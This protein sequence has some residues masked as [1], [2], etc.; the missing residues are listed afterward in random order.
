M[1]NKQWRTIRTFTHT[2]KIYKGNATW[3]ER[4]LLVCQEENPSKSW[5]TLDE[6]IKRA[7]FSKNHSS[8]RGAMKVSI[9]REVSNAPQIL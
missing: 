7:Y 2:T 6:M 8:K 9:I 4:T 1:R 3:E 5:H